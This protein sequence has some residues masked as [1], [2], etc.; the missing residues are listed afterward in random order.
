MARPNLPTIPLKRLETDRDEAAEQALSFVVDRFLPDELA[1]VPVA[2]MIVTWSELGLAFLGYGAQVDA[3]HN[4]I[5]KGLARAAEILTRPYHLKLESGS[6]RL[7]SVP[8]RDLLETLVK[9]QIVLVDRHNQQARVRLVAPPI[10]FTDACYNYR[11]RG[12]I[13]EFTS[14]FGPGIHRP[15]YVAW[16]PS[17]TYV[18]RPA[19]P[20]HLAD[21]CT[22]G[23]VQHRTNSNQSGQDS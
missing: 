19:M 5:G 18:P 23:R 20:E 4:A 12:T 6:I 7:V 8:R 21:I 9:L 11:W 2:D 13:F 14:G 3:V 15:R 22:I 1:P 17:S 16:H 10:G